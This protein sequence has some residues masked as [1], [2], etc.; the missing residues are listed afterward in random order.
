[1]SLFAVQQFVGDLVE[2]EAE[3]EPQ[4]NGKDFLRKSAITE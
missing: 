2:C 1:M 3:R 4:D